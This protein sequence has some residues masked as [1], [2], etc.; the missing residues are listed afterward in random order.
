MNYITVGP[1]HFVDE[2]DNPS[3]YLLEE[4]CQNT[5]FKLKYEGSIPGVMC[6]DLVFNNIISIDNLSTYNI[7]QQFPDLIYAKQVYFRGERGF[8]FGNLELVDYLNIYNSNYHGH[9]VQ[10]LIAKSFLKVIDRNILLINN[11]KITV[12]KYWNVF[13]FIKDDNYENFGF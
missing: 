5:P 9:K 8:N 6:T 1:E 2:N 4:Y 11:K 13:G 10:I 12:K 3:L 7:G